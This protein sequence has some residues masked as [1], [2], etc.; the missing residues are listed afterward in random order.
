MKS[1]RDRAMAPG[2]SSS[3][4]PPAGTRQMSEAAPPSAGRVAARLGPL[5]PTDLL[6]AT[7]FLALGIG[8]VLRPYAT[9][10]LMPGGLGDPRFILSLLEFFYRTLIAALHGQP[11]NFVDAP[12]FYPW[13][14]V[15]NFS[16]T[17]WGDAEVYAPARALGL[18]SLASFQTWFVAGF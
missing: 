15:T 10:R 16:E 11:A 9:G 4:A 14:R 8:L 12:F 5:W 6:A 18:G 13:P 3:P 2:N 1:R 17:F 7:L